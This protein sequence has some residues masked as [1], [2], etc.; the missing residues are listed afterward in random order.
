MKILITTDLF[1][2]ETNGV[3]TSVKNLYE[4]LKEKGHDIRILTLSGNRHSHK[5]GDVYY[6]RSVSIGKIYPNVR[7]PTSYRHRLIKELI[8][9]R[10]DVIH[11]QCEFFTFQYA[12]RISRLT[13]APLVHTYHTLYEQ[14]VP[15]LIPSQRVGNKVVQIISKKRLRPVDQIIVPTR[16]VET[17]LH[18]YGLDA[19]ISVVPSGISLEQHHRRISPQVRQQMR[20]EL[21]IGE[22]QPVLLNLGRL[23]TEKNLDELVRF[24]ASAL[25][26]H[27]DLIFLIVGDGPAR[28]H[29]EKLAAELG[30]SNQ[31]IFTGM[32][33]PTLVQEYYQLADIFVSA[34][35]SETQGLTYV[36]AAANGLPLLCRQD[37]CLK[38]IIVQGENGYEYTNE[39]EFLDHLDTMLADPQ[40]CKAAGT[41]SNQIASSFS[42]DAFGDAVEQVY[43]SVIHEVP[44]C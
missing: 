36:E 21:G 3:V 30:V 11:S 12:Q 24:F 31:V 13:G 18:R 38:D 29:L 26:R 7:M 22:E 41:R 33:S 43:E 16:K 2:T 15:Y 28:E 42:K 4:E 10:P 14:Y 17:T 1:T 5:E 40:W 20:R 35:T 44:S 27:S 32:V 25:Q 39:T 19:P 23:G 6:I 37:L 8:D 9:W 34:S